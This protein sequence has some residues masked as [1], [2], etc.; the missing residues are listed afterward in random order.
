MFFNH[1]LNGQAINTIA[2]EFF[3]KLA[4]FARRI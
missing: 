3:M 1:L 2:R 4:S